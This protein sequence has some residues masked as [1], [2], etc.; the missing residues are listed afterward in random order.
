MPHRAC[1]DGSLV[2]QA[3]LA[4]GHEAF[5]PLA[6]RLGG[7]LLRGNQGE[8]RASIWMRK[9]RRMRDDRRA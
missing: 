7:Y 2:G 6:D 1:R 9:C 8:R 3:I 4:L 5:D